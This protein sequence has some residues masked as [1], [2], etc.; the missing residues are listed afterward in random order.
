[1][2]M[3]WF[4]PLKHGPGQICFRLAVLLRKLKA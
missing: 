1:M 4:E 3:P 2:D